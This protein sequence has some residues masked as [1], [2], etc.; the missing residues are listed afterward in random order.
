MKHAFH[1]ILAA[2]L[3]ACASEPVRPPE[4]PAVEQYTS[5]AVAEERLAPARREIVDVYVRA[6]LPPH[7]TREH[8]DELET[9]LEAREHLGRIDGLRGRLLFPQDNCHDPRRIDLKSRLPV[10]KPADG[11]P[12]LGPDVV[13]SGP[14]R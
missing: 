11:Y 1:G 2:S 3:A 4:M 5:T 12:A 13:S 9:F 6:E 7:A 8:V 14:A 10:R